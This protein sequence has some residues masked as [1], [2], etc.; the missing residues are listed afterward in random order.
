MSGLEPRHVRRIIGMLSDLPSRDENIESF[1]VATEQ[2]RIDLL[3]DGPN[4]EKILSIETV[5]AEGI[6]NALMRSDMDSLSMWMSAYTHI[7]YTMAFEHG[8]KLGLSLASL[9]LV[10]EE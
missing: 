1:R 9:G 8:N 10:A 3:M 4:F 7:V 6:I 2:I 5:V